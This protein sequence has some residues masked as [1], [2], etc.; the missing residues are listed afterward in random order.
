MQRFELVDCALPRKPRETDNK[1]FTSSVRLVAVVVIETF[2]NNIM[3]CHFIF[4][5]RNFLRK[6]P[7]ILYD[8]RGGQS[9]S[10]P[11]PPK[12]MSVATSTIIFSGAVNIFHALSRV[13]KKL[14]KS[15]LKQTK[16]LSSRTPMILFPF[17]LEQQQYTNGH[18]KST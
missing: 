8:F 2:H 4:S 16:Q 5:R 3:R 11:P 9:L 6:S 10:Q 12:L 15:R 14:P 1:K 7:I 18:G 17:V 13:L